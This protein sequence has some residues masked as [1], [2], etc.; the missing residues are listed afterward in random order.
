M[1][2]LLCMLLPYH[3]CSDS[4][5]FELN[6]N[7]YSEYIRHTFSFEDAFL[8]SEV[9]NFVKEHPDDGMFVIDC[10]NDCGI[11]YVIMGTYNPLHYGGYDFIFP[12]ID[13]F[14]YMDGRIVVI[15]KSYF[16]DLFFK[17]ERGKCKF[18]YQLGKDAVV[19]PDQYMLYKYFLDSEG[20]MIIRK[21]SVEDTGR[22]NVDSL[23]QWVIF[24]L[25]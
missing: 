24:P 10:F 3:L 17:Q 9:K 21:V 13:G 4:Y 16:K 7:V 12:D 14:L 6:G 18:R 22:I 2:S 19:I 25:N 15:M 5:K 23:P 8:E 11:S 20:T 1:A